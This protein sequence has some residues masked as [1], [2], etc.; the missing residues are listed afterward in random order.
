ML[1]TLET[2]SA[3]A[4]ALPPPAPRL[5]RSRLPE[6]DRTVRWVRERVVV[7][8]HES[9]YVPEVEQQSKWELRFTRGKR[10]SLDGLH[11]AA[12]AGQ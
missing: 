2:L 8:T 5:L 12:R 11:F 1:S 4:I 6:A 10:G 3:S 9:E 7:S